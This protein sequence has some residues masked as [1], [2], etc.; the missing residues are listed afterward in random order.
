MNECRE[1][2]LLKKDTAPDRPLPPQHVESP[3]RAARLDSLARKAM[4]AL[5]QGRTPEQ[6]LERE[7]LAELRSRY[8][9]FGDTRDGEDFLVDSLNVITRLSTPRPWIH[10]LVNRHDREHGIY[11]TLW[12]QTGGGFSCLD[13]V[14][15]GQITSNKDN[16]Y[17]PTSPRATDQRFFWLREETGEG[18]EIWHML[19]QWGREEERY[20]GFRCEQGTTSISISASRN[21]IDAALKVFVPLDEPLEAWRLVLGNTSG[22]VRRLSLFVQVNWGLESYPGH[23]FDPR[24]VSEGVVFDRL[25]ALLALNNDTKNLHRRSGWLMSARPFDSFDLTGEDFS[26]GGRQRVFPRAVMEGRCRNS[27]GL[28]PFMGLVGAM[29]FDLEI[30]PDNREE[31]Y[32]LL[33]SSGPD[34]GKTRE[35]LEALRPRFFAPGAFEARLGEVER[36]HGM[37]VRRQ[38]ARTPDEELDRFYNVWSKHQNRNQTRLLLALDMVGYRDILQYLT[39]I[40]AFNPEFTAVQLPTTL[41]HQYP[42]GRAMRQYAKIPN[43]PHDL[44][45][46]MDSSSWIPD[47]LVGYV[48][49]TGDRAILDRKE[50]FYNPET[51][52]VEQEPAATVYEHALRGVRV[53][54]ERRGLHGLCLIGHGDWNDALDGVGAGGGGVSVWLS[55]A[56]VRAAQR[57][58]ELAVLTGDNGSR[59][60]MDR[61]VLEMTETINRHAWDGDHYVYAFM[62]DGRP[63]GASSCEEGK[64]HLNVNSWSLLSSVA[65]AA[66]RVEAVLA[67]VEKVSTPVGCLLIDP[68][69]TARSRH[70]GRIADCAPGQFENGGIYTHGQSFLT[71]ALAEAGLGDRAWAELKK[72]MPS[73]TLPDISTGAPHQISNYTVG[74]AHPHFGR[75]LYSNFT[76]SIAWL[77]RTVERMHGVLAD[78]DSLLLD[79]VL[80]RSWGELRVVK[81]FRGCRVTV[82]ILN[83]S[84]VERGVVS[85]RLGP[86]DLPLENGRARLPSS[87]L[88]G[89]ESALVTV[90]LG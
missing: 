22:R 69:Y 59:D 13:S 41:R 82:E 89:R 74:T 15:A 26:G 53:L 90:V 5:K 76:G 32:F 49:E 68:P 27:T 28:Q 40:S 45:M 65:Q 33:G 38:M 6:V 75:N 56:L 52:R 70:V 78:F 35:E 12:D 9:G 63:V 47:T 17:V 21:G 51:G 2:Q 84:G 34:R 50:G 44:R 20:D 64:I 1:D 62:P 42:D 18:V 67:A 58:R 14:L 16:S 86:E 72:L 79:P 55:M 54:Y 77:R 46:Y 66:G 71:Y 87:L 73:T 19:P 83:P 29:H 7:E 37:H 85:A 31:L 11:G 3:E 24:V 80:P 81:Q 43:G 4:A 36:H 30:P 8:G 57:F 10:F 48:K 60:L 25:N 61:I 88:E 23:W 39:G